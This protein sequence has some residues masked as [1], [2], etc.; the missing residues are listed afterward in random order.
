MKML[1]HGENGKGASVGSVMWSHLLQQFINYQKIRK[2]L[3]FPNMWFLRWPGMLLRSVKVCDHIHC[4]LALPRPLLWQPPA[5]SCSLLQPSFSLHTQLWPEC[6]E[7]ANQQCPYLSKKSISIFSFWCFPWPPVQSILYPN[8][9]LCIIFWFLWPWSFLSSGLNF[10][11][12]LLL[13]LFFRLP[14]PQTHKQ[15][16]CKAE[17]MVGKTPLPMLTSVAVIL[18]RRFMDSPVFSIVVFF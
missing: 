17:G 1:Y 8:Y 4:P 6:L 10:F 3:C 13:I 16:L 2:P 7:R 14:P 12:C 5:A 11:C 15:K 9:F 18:H